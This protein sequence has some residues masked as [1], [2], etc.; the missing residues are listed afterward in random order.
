MTSTP[1]GSSGATPRFSCILSPPDNTDETLTY[2]ERVV[3]QSLTTDG[4]TLDVPGTKSTRTGGFIQDLPGD[5][6]SVGVYRCSSTSTTSGIS[7]SADL[8]ILSKDSK[9]N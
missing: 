1:F 3:V 5:V 9:Y 4:Y 7:S 2:T 6:T 8:T